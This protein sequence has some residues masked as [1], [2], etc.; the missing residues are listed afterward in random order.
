MSLNGV[1]EGV[2][3]SGSRSAYLPQQFAWDADTHS[4]E[5]MDELHQRI[6]QY[7][8]LR[9]SLAKP[10]S[11]GATE[12]TA[13]VLVTTE[14]RSTDQGQE[15]LER[16][17]PAAE[18]ESQS[19][20]A[21]S[22]AGLE[23]QT[24]P[25]TEQA[26]PINL[27]APE[28]LVRQEASEEDRPQVFVKSQNQANM[29]DGL[30]EGSSAAMSVTSGQ[31]QASS[32]LPTKEPPAPANPESHP[33]SAIPKRLLVPPNPFAALS[34]SHSSFTLSAR[35]AKEKPTVTT[36]EVL[37]RIETLTQTLIK[38]SEEKLGLASNA[39]DLVR[40]VSIISLRS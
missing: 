21:G 34:R 40:W 10:A 17:D 16:D 18:P 3:R 11:G 22:A 37:R 19:L 2:G 4:V 5:C 14:P 6:R 1:D 28:S 31:E 13:L 8:Q 30:E 38:A 39:Y 32:T 26:S 33:P 9:V 29:A 35:K 15:S 12:K 25:K 27:D 23:E 24:I 36:T 20:C 7:I